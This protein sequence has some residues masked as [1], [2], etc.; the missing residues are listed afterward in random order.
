[1]RHFG[2]DKEVL[3]CHA[4]LGE[5]IDDDRKLIAK[6]CKQRVEAC[7]SE[8]CYEPNCEMCK[9]IRDDL[10]EQIDALSRSFIAEYREYP[11]K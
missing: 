6:L 3:E 11:I 7:C 9:I 4:M 1:M 5:S 10:T 2:D 8:D